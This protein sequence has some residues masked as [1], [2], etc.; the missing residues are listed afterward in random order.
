ME[1]INTENKD[2]VILTEEGHNKLNEELNKL[3]NVKRNE[4]AERL[5]QAISYGDITENSE[6]DDAKNEQAR[7]EYRIDTIET[8]LANAKVISRRQVKTKE[9]G[10]GSMVEIK[11]VSSGK[12]SQRYRIVGSAEANA[13]E[14]SISFQSPVGQALMGLKVGDVARVS[15]PAGE[16]KYRVL[17]IKK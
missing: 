4:I 6:Y 12:K 16:K 8:I 17:T 3:K 15:A 9:V 11:Q 10:I 1:L 14:H 5:K 7:I 2:E 13:E